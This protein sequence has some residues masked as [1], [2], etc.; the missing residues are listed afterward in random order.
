MRQDLRINRVLC[1]DELHSVTLKQISGG[2]KIFQRGR[3]P[4]E[5]SIYY[6]ANFENEIYIRPRGGAHP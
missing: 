2:S 5:A 3:K 6:L 1:T 4:K